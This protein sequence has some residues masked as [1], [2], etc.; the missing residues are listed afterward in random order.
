MED[1]SFVSISKFN[2]GLL[3]AYMHAFPLDS[4][5]NQFLLLTGFLIKIMSEIKS[6]TH[7]LYLYESHN[8]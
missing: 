1:V 3:I 5:W 4:P 7:I 2:S 8:F 6:L